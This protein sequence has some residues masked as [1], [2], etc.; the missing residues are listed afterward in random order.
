MRAIAAAKGVSAAR[1]AIALVAAQGRDIV[2]LVGARRRE[3]L[4]DR[5]GIGTLS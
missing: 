2:P 1:I 5:R 3:R 4:A